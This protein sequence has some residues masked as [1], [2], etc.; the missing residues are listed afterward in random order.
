MNLMSSLMCRLGRHNPYRRNVTWDGHHYVGKCRHCGAPIER[1][2][3]R[4]WRK[5]SSVRP[6]LTPEMRS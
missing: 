3:R 1:V 2:S 5:A 4:Q 6:T